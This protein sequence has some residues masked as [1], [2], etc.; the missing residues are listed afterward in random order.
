MAATKKDSTDDK[1]NEAAKLL[2]DQMP[3]HTSQLIEKLAEQA[4][5]PLWQMVCGILLAQYSAGTLSIYQIDPAW[6]DGLRKQMN[7][8]KQCGKMFKS[9]HIG[10]PYCTNECGLKAIGQWHEEEDEGVKERVVADS[11]TSADA[12]VVAHDSGWADGS[13]LPAA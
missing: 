3:D 13:A 9:R 8:C 2:I 12:G 6:K 5:V 1:F 4:Y 10:Q 7:K 11:P